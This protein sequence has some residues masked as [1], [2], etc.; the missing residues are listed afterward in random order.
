MKPDNFKRVVIEDVRPEVDAGQFPAKRVIGERVVVQADIFCDGHDRPSAA[1]LYRVKG[2]RKW[3]ELRMQLLVNDRWSAMFRVHELGIYEFTVRGWVDHYKTW[4][5]DLQK[6]LEAGQDVSVE[7]LIAARLIAQAAERAEERDKRRM[8]EWVE[9]LQSDAASIGEKIAL[10]NDE[11]VLATASS[12]PDPRFVEQYPRILEIRVDPPRARFSSWYELFPRSAAADQ[13]RHGTFQDVERQLPR[14]AE[15]GFDV[16]YFPPIHPIGTTNRKGAN[17]SLGAAR[18]DVGSPWAIGNREGGHKSIH[19]ELGT[20]DDFKHLVE[21][22]RDEF[23]I[24]IALDIAFQ[25]SPDHPWVREHP[26]WFRH[27]PDGSIQFAENPPKRYEDIYPFDFESDQW[28]SLW[29]ELLNIVLYWCQQG[30][31]IFRIDN[32]HTKPLRLWDFLIEQVKLRYPDAIFLAEAFTRPKVMYRL[33]KGGFT[34]SYTYFAWRNDQWGLTRYMRELT[35]APVADFFRPNFWPNTPDILNEYL[36][37]GGRQ[38][39][40]IRLVLAATLA[41]SYGIYGP[42]FELL[43]NTPREPGSEEYQDSEKYQIR[44]WALDQPGNLSD[45]LSI[46]NQIRREQ[47]ALQTNEFLRFHHT[48]ND[49]IICY[50]KTDEAGANMILVAVNLDPFNTQSC[51]V[52]LDAEVLGIEPDLEYQVHDL[53][54]DERYRW[55]GLRNFVQLNPWVIPAHVFRVR[56]HVRSERDF[57]YFL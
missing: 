46:V 4:H 16:L 36:Q 54:S 1:V 19:P 56:R 11:A 28:E 2:V 53:I 45:L 8:S 32:P 41:A 39:F 29:E 37:R 55:R 50:S 15:L 20:L 25:C 42:A 7:M 57:D 51:W 40:V 12:Y 34:Q 5:I 23:G 49:Q 14:I 43:E 38:A 18:D 22:A 17:N 10:V 27:R 9:L 13:E 44:R 21:R 6:R 30:V 33:A 31:R 47:P 35:S 24:D 48:S 52:E 3:T 26:E